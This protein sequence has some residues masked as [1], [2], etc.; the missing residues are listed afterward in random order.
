[1]L[2]GAGSDGAL[3][4]DFTGLLKPIVETVDRHGLKR[5]FLGIYRNSVH[6]FYNRLAD[7]AVTSELAEK[8]VTR[9]QK[10]RNGMFTF[11]D[12]DNVPWNNNNAEHAVKAFASIQRVIEGPTTEKGFRNFLVL[13]SIAKRANI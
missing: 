2:S 9:L 7:W 8:L 11:L 1:M 3:V 12:F 6:R 5:R 4:G 10:T 13:L